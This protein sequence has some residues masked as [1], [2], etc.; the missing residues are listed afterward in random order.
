MLEN[1]DIL[2]SFEPHHGYHYLLD[3]LPLASRSALECKQ[4]RGTSAE[5]LLDTASGACSGLKIN[6]MKPT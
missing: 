3:R 6:A 5:P 1:F 4:G 2:H